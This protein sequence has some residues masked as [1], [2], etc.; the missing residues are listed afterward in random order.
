M[1]AARRR[2]AYS[3]CAPRSLSP[4]FRVDLGS[5]LGRNVVTQGAG[6][7]RNGRWIEHA[8]DGPE[9]DVR[10]NRLMWEW[11]LALRGHGELPRLMVLTEE[12][13]VDTQKVEH[14]TVPNR[15]FFEL[16]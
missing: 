8:G 1:P 9:V 6:V 5:E 11:W 10:A 12:T 4:A 14:A 3:L 13:P 2:S 7:Y 16:N 15:D